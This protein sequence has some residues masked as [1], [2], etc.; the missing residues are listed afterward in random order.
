[1]KN[2]NPPAP[3][4]ARLSAKQ[5]TN[6]KRNISIH[7]P[8]A[9]R[10]SK[11][12]QKIS[13]DLCILYKSYQKTCINFPKLYFYSCTTWESVHFISDFRCEPP[14]NIMAAS[15]S[16]RTRICYERSIPFNLPKCRILIRI[17]RYKRIPA[18]SKILPSV[19]ILALSELLTLCRVCRFLFSG[20]SLSHV[21]GS[22]S[23]QT[24]TK[25]SERLLHHTI[26]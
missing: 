18:L 9:G 3:R 7:P 11:S 5:E 20:K 15:A 22:I 4:G 2:F 13:A 12:P 19:G 10:D 23:F 26:P 8:L 21:I 25:S 6:R 1:M 16:H 14:R 17:S 24:V